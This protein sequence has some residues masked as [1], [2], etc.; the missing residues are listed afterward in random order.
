M[1][2]PMDGSGS[3]D[4]AAVIA[5][6]GVERPL[7]GYRR[8][9]VETPYG[10]AVV[11]RASDAEPIF[12]SRHGV[13][14]DIPPHRINYRANLHALRQLGITHALATYTVGSIVEDIAPGDLVLVDQLLD[15][16]SGR[17]ATFFDGGESGVEHVDLTEPFCRSLGQQLVA[18]AADSHVAL[19]KTGTYVCTNGPRLETAAEIQMYAMLRGEVVGMTALPEASLAR[20]VGIHYAGVAVSVNW[21][22]G[23]RGPVLIDRDAQ[24]TARSRLLPLLIKALRIALPATCLCRWK[25]LT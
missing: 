2:E 11:Y 6:S 18:A 1:V 14:H 22:A 20:E 7:P 5:G 25:T 21:A 10:I 9:H 16:T 3:M 17:A 12:L 19:R 15:F 24:A 13:E 8:Q 23:V 4:R